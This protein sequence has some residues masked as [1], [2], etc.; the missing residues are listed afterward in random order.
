MASDWGFKSRARRE[1]NDFSEAEISNTNDGKNKNKI[2]RF[3]ES[4]AISMKIK[5]HSMH[6]IAASNFLIK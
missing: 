3:W 4:T 5:N 1:L 2:Y 6:K